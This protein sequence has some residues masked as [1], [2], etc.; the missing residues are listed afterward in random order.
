MDVTVNIGVPFGY[1]NGF[2]SLASNEHAISFHLEEGTHVATSAIIDLGSVHKAGGARLLGQF[3]FTYTWSSADRIVTVCGSD[4]DSPDTM[5]L[6][7]WPEG[8]QEICRQR[9]SGGGFRYQDLKANPMWNYTTPLTPGVEDIFDGLVKGA[10]EKLIQALQATPDI[11]VQVR[12][13]VPKLSPDVHEQLMLVYRNG[14]FDRVHEANT[15]LGSNEQLYTIESTF[16]GEVTL[17]YKEAFANVIGSTSDPKI[18][19]LSWIQLWA[20]QYGQYPVICTSY[21]SNGFNC[22]NSLVGGHVIGGKTA[23]SMPKGSNSV[24]IFPICIQHNN[25]DKVYM[26]ALKYLK[27][28]WLNNYLGP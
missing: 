12:R 23:K 19:G 10:N 2:V 24:W 9:A 18:A 25:D 14:V 27:G 6:A 15:L 20:N 17:N 26:E 28:I 5:T 13:P 8:T 16:G 22:G 1:D 4:F 3:S 7:T 11:A 21:H